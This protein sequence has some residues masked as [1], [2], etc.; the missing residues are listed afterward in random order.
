M[1]FL[2]GLFLGFTFGF[3]VAALCFIAREKTRN[4]LAESSRHEVVQGAAGA[5]RA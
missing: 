3:M 5:Q 4:T 2:L 1:S